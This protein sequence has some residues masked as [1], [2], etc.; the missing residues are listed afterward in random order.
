[1]TLGL[2]ASDPIDH[3]SIFHGYEL[4]TIRVG[5]IKRVGLLV[6]SESGAHGEVQRTPIFNEL[7]GL[8]IPN[9]NAGVIAV[10]VQ[11]NEPAFRIHR[12]SVNAVELSGAASFDTADD[13][14]EPSIFIELDDA[15]VL[16]TVR[17]EDVTIGSNVNIARTIER[18][19]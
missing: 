9:R 14:D 15:V 3:F 18:G 11:D 1:M 7:S 12:D 5:N 2:E 6:H 17:D 19:L 10:M 13:L 16:V 4:M 8:R